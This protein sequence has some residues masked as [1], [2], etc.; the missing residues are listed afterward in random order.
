[1]F[2]VAAI[3]SVIASAAVI[4]KVIHD[5]RNPKKILPWKPKRKWWKR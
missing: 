5:R 1:M 4:V 3:M 2:L